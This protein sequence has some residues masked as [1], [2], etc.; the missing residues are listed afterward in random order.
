MPFARPNSDTTI[1]NYTDQAGGTTN[2][3]N[4][5]DDSAT[6]DTDYIRSPAAPANEVYVTKLSSIADPGVSTGHI[7]RYRYQKDA[8]GGGQIDLTIQLRQG[9]VSEAT[10][11]TLI[12]SETIT[13]IQNN[14]TTGTFTLTAVET[15]SITNYADLYWRIV[16]NQI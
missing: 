14:W 15:D 4:A 3:Y 11:G 7:L 9:Y 2:I 5:I 8:T 16:A 13:N 6:N 1:G 12:H 10:Q